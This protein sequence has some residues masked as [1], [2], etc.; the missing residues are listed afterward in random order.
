MDRLSERLSVAQR[1]L[2]ALESVLALARSDDIARDAAI[3]RFEFSLETVWKAAQLWLRE[4]AGE[5][6]SSPKG[7]VR[8]ANAATIIDEST[9]I[10]LLAAID[11]RNLTVHTY[12]ER[13]AAD[14]TSRLPTHARAMRALLAALRTRP[15]DLR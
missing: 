12:S 8:A 6:V 14:V 15:A 2:D 5:D 1:A 4:H 10:Q 11:D 9:A 7:V 3:Q 13:T